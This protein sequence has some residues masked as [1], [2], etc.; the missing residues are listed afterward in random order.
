MDESVGAAQLAATRRNAMGERLCLAAL[1][2]AVVVLALALHRRG[3]S[4]G[5]DFALYLDQARSL[6]RGDAYEVIEDNRFN[7]LNA[8]TPT[9]S[10]YGY[11]WVW[12]LVLSPFV[13]VIGLDLDRLA[14]VEVLLLALVVIALHRLVRRRAS[15]AVALLVSAVVGLSPSILAHTDRLLTEIPHLLAVLATLLWLDRLTCPTA[16]RSRWHTATTRELVVLGL[17][18]A[19]AFNV[20]REGMVLVAAIAAAQL[21]AR[22]P[23]RRAIV[24][25]VAFVG[26]AALFHLLLPTALLPRYPGD[27]LANASPMFG[28][29]LPD[30]IAHHLSLGADGRGFARWF[31]LVALVAGVSRLAMH[32]R[33]D[34]ALVVVPVLT[35]ALFAR[36]PFGY[37]PRY[38]IQVLPFALYAIAQFPSTVAELLDLPRRAH[39]LAAAVAIVALVGLTAVQV[40]HLPSEVSAA[41]DHDAAGRVQFGPSD[42]AVM[43]VLDAVERTTP[44]DAIVA[45]M[46]ARTMT[47]YTDR[48]SVQ[49]SDL[50]IILR[51]ADYFAMLRGSDF[52]QPLVD[53][54]DAEAYGLVSVW[55][56]ELWVLWRIDARPG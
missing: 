28:E 52:S 34:I 4:W 6:W 53:E 55:E 9:F 49:S 5:D 11:P 30:A 20:R 35:L 24:P 22:A 56:D 29:W 19:V 45:F 51:R 54:A 18:A 21:V 14:L 26:A 47:L 37:D 38:Y 10:P 15:A 27:G 16:T 1:V 46:K 23:W 12:P 2:A 32:A 36:F 13:A 42:P 3:H 41:R 33:A 48:R 40:W 25:H 43:A 8:A 39:H 44:P 50:G 17:L 7:V 31:L